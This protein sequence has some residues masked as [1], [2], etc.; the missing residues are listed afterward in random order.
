LKEENKLTSAQLRW[1][2]VAE[3]GLAAVSAGNDQWQWDLLNI[4]LANGIVHCK[5]C[6]AGNAGRRNAAE[7]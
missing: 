5:S 4:Y 6:A 2:P 7:A 3:E 1:L